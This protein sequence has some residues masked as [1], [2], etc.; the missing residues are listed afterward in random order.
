MGYFNEHMALPATLLRKPKKKEKYAPFL[1]DMGINQSYLHFGT[2]V[3]SYIFL[4]SESYIS[5]FN[6]FVGLGFNIEHV[7][8]VAIKLFTRL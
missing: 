1:Y 5:K 3:L 2:R 6:F 4:I 7:E 8:Y